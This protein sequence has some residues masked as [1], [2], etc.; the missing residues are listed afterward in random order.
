[1]S[2]LYQIRDLAARQKAA[3]KVLE[4]MSFEVDLRRLSRPLPKRPSRLR[5]V[6][7]ADAAVVEPQ[8]NGKT[9]G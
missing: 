1:M 8:E 7:D 3:V 4:E 2:D 5:V 9:E 6:Y